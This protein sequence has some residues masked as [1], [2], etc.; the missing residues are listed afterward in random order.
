MAERRIEQVRSQIEQW[1]KARPY[2]CSPMPAVLWRR[3]VGLAEEFG[4]HP[5]KCA[6]SLSYQSLK[7]R[8]EEGSAT[9]AGRRHTTRAQF[10][11]IKGGELLGSAAGSIVE[12][13]DSGGA[14]LTVRLAAGSEVDLAGLVRAFRKRK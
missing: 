4:V 9:G 2:Q 6:L 10:V 14:R 1:R 11:E 5:V 8:V 3:A 7:K 12:V 13:S